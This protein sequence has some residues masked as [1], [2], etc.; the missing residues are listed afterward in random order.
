MRGKVLDVL[1]QHPKILAH[2]CNRRLSSGLVLTRRWIHPCQ[3]PSLTARAPRRKWASRL[4]PT[5]ATWQC[6]LRLSLVLRMLRKD[7]QWGSCGIVLSPESTVALIGWRSG[8]LA[9]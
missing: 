2:R 3:Q 7:L 4:L 1:R 9:I 6:V 5:G 8:P